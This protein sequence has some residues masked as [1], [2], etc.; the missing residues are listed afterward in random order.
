MCFAKIGP[1]VALYQ[2]YLQNVGQR[3]IVGIQGVCTVCTVLQ[4]SDQWCRRLRVHR[5]TDEVQSIVS[6]HAFGLVETITFRPGGDNNI[7][8]CRKAIQNSQ[9]HESQF[10][11]FQ[12]SAKP[13]AMALQYSWMGTGMC[14]IKASKIAL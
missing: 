10:G 11:K 12:R 14:S 2:A 8:S 5:R 7:Y 6:P 13:A 3:F 1:M 9:G 4:Q